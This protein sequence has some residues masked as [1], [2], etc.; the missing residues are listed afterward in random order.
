MARLRQEFVASG[1]ADE[2]AIL[3]PFLTAEKGAIRYAEVA[4][5]LG[6]TEGALRVAA[7][8]LRRRY[9]DLFREE[10]AHTVA[11]PAE[12]EEE[13]RHLIGVLRE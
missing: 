13:I 2:F 12:I 7:H 11:D 9:R 1:R 10:I 3:K 8:R 6:L 4:P 5:H